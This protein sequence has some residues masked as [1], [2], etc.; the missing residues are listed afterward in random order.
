MGLVTTIAHTAPAL[1]IAIDNISMFCEISL[2]IF[3]SLR[4][5]ISR[6][7][8]HCKTVDDQ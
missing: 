6:L 2:H 7:H 3:P 1:L 8:G 4:Y 5:L